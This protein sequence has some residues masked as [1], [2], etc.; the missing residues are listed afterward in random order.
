[1]PELPTIAEAGLPGF[2]ASAWYGMVAPVRVPKEII[3]KLNREI[4][5]LL[6]D[7]QFREGMIARGAVPWAV[8][9]TSSTRSSGVKS[10]NTPRW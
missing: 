1:M 8:A 2:E 5:E 4:N 6:R 10:E 7:P 9:A 3:V